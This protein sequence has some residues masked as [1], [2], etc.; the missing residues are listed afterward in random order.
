MT[1]DA[2]A[3]WQKRMGEVLKAIDEAPDAVRGRFAAW[4]KIKSDPS[5]NDEARF[6]LAMSGYVAGQDEAVADLAAADVLWLARA[7]LRAVE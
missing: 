6:A 1:S 7:F 4:Q 2:R 5:K 3:P